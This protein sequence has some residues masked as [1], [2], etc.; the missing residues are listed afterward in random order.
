MRGMNK[1]ML[2]GRVGA[3]IAPRKTRGGVMLLELR[4]ATRRPT[5]SG[6]EA[7]D[8]HRVRLWGRLAE[9][10]SEEL[11]AGDPLAVEGQLRTEG[12]IDREG[13]THQRA[14]IHAEQVHLIPT[15]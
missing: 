9:Q 5:R 1:V 3:P 4:L 10:C 12:W 8:W 11:A 2:L 6:E 15:A 14:F 7:T 13:R